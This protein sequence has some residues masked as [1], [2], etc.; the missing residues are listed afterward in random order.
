MAFHPYLNFGGNCR[1]AFTRY[2]EIFGG[3]LDVMTMADMPPGEQ[4]VPAE[5]A[6]LVMH[7][8]LRVGDDI[9][10]ASDDPTTDDFGPVQGM[11]VNYSV[12]DVDEARR[13]FDALAEG[14]QITMP[15]GE[16]FWAPLF[17]MC[18][19]R[20]GTPWMVNAEGPESAG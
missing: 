16:T 5:Q 18:V 6:D 7:A 8:A 4:E 13:V 3:E 12:A 14:G 9:L 17:G 10:M 2:Q 15:A 1:E 11:Y 19:D 20:F